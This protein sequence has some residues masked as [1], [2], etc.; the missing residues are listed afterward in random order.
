MSETI[1]LTGHRKS[2][3]SVFSKL[4]DNHPEL[5]IY[6]TDVALLYAYFPHYV[7]T[8]PE[9]LSA[10]IS[11]IKHVVH[12]SLVE[13]YNTYRNSVK[14]DVAGF[15]SFFCSRLEIAD[16]NS[17]GKLLLCL[18]SCWEDFNSLDSTKKFVF[19]ETSQAAFFEMYMK[20]CP[21]LKM[22]NL[23]R[24]PR[25]NYAAIKAGVEKYYSKLGEDNLVSLASLLQ[26]ARMDLLS[27]K[28]CAEFS[29]QHFMNVK[30]ENLVCD[31]EASIKKCCNFL[32]VD[33][34]SSLLIPTVSGIPYEGNSHDGI[35]FKG[36]SSENVG[37]WKHRISQEEAMIVEFWMEN[38]MKSFGYE[39]SFS[40]QDSLAAYS[41]FYQ[42]LNTRYFFSDRFK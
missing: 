42:W 41:E 32:G 15:V 19:K 17:R 28:I 8:K 22:L 25:D 38:E 26:R 24:D 23:V 34:Q 7:P 33:F 1:L 27:A 11:R 14:F 16:L 3:T 21:D 5:N 30:F 13:H 2:G 37:Q 36:L 31:A 40:H 20:D 35:S 12:I 9:D 4:F 10:S 39:L 6:P 29:P 18:R